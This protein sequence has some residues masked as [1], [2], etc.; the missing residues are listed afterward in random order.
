MNN[1]GNVPSLGEPSPPIWKFVPAPKRGINLNPVSLKSYLYS[2][3]IVYNLYYNQKYSDKRVP[4][5]AKTFFGS[6]IFR[7]QKSYVCLYINAPHL[8]RVP[9][10]SN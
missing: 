4:S 1:N 8:F 7:Y 9:F 3:S 5:L 10:C 6:L 2:E